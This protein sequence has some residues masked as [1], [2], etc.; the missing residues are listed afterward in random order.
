[1]ILCSKAGGRRRPGRTQSFLTVCLIALF[2][3]IGFESLDTT[4]LENIQQSKW[5]LRQ[6]SNYETYIRNIQEHGIMV[7]GA[8]IT[9]L[10]HDDVS[11]FA[12][13]VDFMD[14][15]YITGQITVATPFPGTEYFRYLKKNNLSLSENWDD[16]DGNYRCVVRGAD[17]TPGE[18][19]RLQLQLNRI[20]PVSTTR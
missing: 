19:E 10:D 8:F 7:F 4:N 20:N 18:L 3:F 17:L 5:K 2:L 6:L 1:M 11:V 13:T 12:R 15:N 16:Y 9:C 14:R